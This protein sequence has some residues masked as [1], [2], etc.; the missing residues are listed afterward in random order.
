MG[1]GKTPSLIAAEL[2]LSLP[3]V[4]VALRHLREIDLVR[5]ENL[6]EGK[7]YFVKDRTITLILELLEKLV[8]NIKTHEY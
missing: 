1:E 2:R 4:S 8:E 6:K 5:Y 3:T 7:V